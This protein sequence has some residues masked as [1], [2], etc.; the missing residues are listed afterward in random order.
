M[1]DRKIKVS[2]I[3][4]MVEILTESIYHILYEYL[5]MTKQCSRVPHSLTNDQ[6]HQ[7]VD[8]LKHALTLFQRNQTDFLRRFVTIEEKWIHYYTLESKR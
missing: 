7:R 1:D 2:Q 4:D 6:K 8:D 3:A 5:G